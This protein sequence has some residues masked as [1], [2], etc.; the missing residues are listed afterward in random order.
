MWPLAA[1]T[2]AHV[3]HDT[4]NRMWRSI[5][6]WNCSQLSCPT[7]QM[8]KQQYSASCM[9][10]RTSSAL[11]AL[12][13]LCNFKKQYVAAI[14]SHITRGATFLFVGLG[15]FAAMAL[16]LPRQKSAAKKGIMQLQHMMVSQP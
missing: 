4:H 5:N 14:G 1:L 11:Y 7:R 15:D 6:L 13:Q 12:Q 16:G 3:A 9:A 8:N 10:Q 2:A